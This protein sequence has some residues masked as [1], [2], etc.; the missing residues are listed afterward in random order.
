MNQTIHRL[1]IGCGRDIKKGYVNLDRAKLPG[2]DVVC[3]INMF[4]WPFPNNYFDEVYCSH[5]L[6]HVEDLVRVMEEISRIC[7]PGAKIKIIGP[8][9][10]G[11]GAYN[12]PTHKQFMTYLTFDYFKE[13]GYYSK[14]SFKII[15]K[16]IMFL[17]SRTFLTSKWYGAHLDFSINLFPIMY[18][19][20]WCW[21][22]PASEIHYLLRVLKK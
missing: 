6:E 2:V 19:R 13:G 12:D 7:K 20:F 8:Y 21:I 17:S 14:V 11:H 1:N 9:F 5:V 15:R 10:A 3:N 22:L 16:K 4:P 18:Q